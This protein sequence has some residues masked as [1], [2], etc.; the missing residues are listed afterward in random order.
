MTD[1]DPLTFFQAFERTLLINDIGKAE[2][3]KFLVCCLT[4]KANKVLSGLS[5]DDNKDFDKC[6]QAILSYFRLDAP[7]YR[8][9]FQEA[10]KMPEET[11]KMFK[12]RIQDYFLYYVEAKGIS[13]LD[14]L[15]DD[16]GFW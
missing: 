16:A 10:C 14:D 7:A 15:V 13:S 8:K 1:S 3:L 6:K 5:L 2:W 12:T 4:V 11:H 9:R